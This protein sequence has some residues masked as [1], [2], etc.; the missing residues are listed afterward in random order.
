M[1]IARAL[2]LVAVCSSLARAAT[3][4]PPER[5]ARFDEQQGRVRMTV[6]YPEL[7]DAAL[8]NKLSSGLGATFVARAYLLREGGARAE[9]LAVQ[10]ARIAYDLWDEVYVVEI[11]DADGRRLYREPRREDAVRRAAG[12]ERL[13]VAERARLVPG[14]RYRVAVIVEVDPVSPELLRQ[15]RRWLARPRTGGPIAEGESAFGSFVGSLVETR[16]GDAERVLRFRT[17][18]FTVGEAP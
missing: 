18:P 16:I 3:P 13:V 15:V 7:V 14:A 10:T 1:I 12:L 6:A 17:Q 5:Q 8:Q 11:S 4:V 9:A 2:A